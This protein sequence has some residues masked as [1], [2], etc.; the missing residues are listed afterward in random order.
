MWIILEFTYTWRTISSSFCFCFLSCCFWFSFLYRMFNI[1]LRFYTL[2][3]KTLYLHAL[4][5]RWNH[6]LHLGK[7]S[8]LFS[9]SL[10]NKKPVSDFFTFYYE[11]S[12]IHILPW[13]LSYI[14]DYWLGL[15]KEKEGMA[16]LYIY[17]YIILY[18][19]LY[20]T[21]II[22]YRNVL[23]LFQIYHMVYD[24]RIDQ[25]LATELLSSMTS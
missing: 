1:L 10:E 13:F 22:L 5:M 15:F 18:I 3:S 20:I 7:L 17:I 12:T 8:S 11:Y 4:I 16:D 25:H 14:K 23:P 9:L 19:I 24:Y 21:L 2:L 6:T